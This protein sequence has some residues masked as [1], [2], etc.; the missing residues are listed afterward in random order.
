VR[1]EFADTL[2]LVLD[3][4]CCRVGVESTILSLV[5]EEPILLRP[6]G[7]SVR[8]L[9]EVLGYRVRVQETAAGGIRV[10]GLLASHYATRTPLQIDTPER[11]WLRAKQLRAQG[12]RLAFMILRNPPIESC[13]TQRKHII[14]MPNEPQAYA[15][16]LYHTMRSL[17]RGDYDLLLVEAP[18]Q[19]EGWSAVNNRLLRAAA[20][21]TITGEIENDR[22]QF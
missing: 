7:I 1:E 6:G 8:H 21:G 19:T 15:R 5:T 13:L 11:L 10:P 14:E 12:L 17:D 9:A 22:E 2:E 18:P 20:T 3:G 16:R 4:G